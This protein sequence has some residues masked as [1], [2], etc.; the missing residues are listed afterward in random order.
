MAL[1]SS[2]ESDLQ[3]RRAGRQEHPRGTIQPKA[4]LV[5]SRSFTQR[6]ES[7][8]V[9]LTPGKARVPRHHIYRPRTL[10]RTESAP[11]PSGG[12]PTSPNS[13]SP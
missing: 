13:R 10:G 2:F 7:E 5:R 9:K 6:L 8:P 4:P 1:P 11:Q 12:V 3:D